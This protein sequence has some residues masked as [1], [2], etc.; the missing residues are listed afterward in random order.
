MVAIRRLRVLIMSGHVVGCCRLLCVTL[1]CL[2]LLGYGAESLART[3]WPEDQQRLRVGLRIFPAVLDALEG[4]GQRRSATGDLHVVVTYQ[5][6]NDVVHQVVTALEE[7]EQVQ[8]MPLTL[9]VLALE[10]LWTYRGPALGGI[11]VA[12]AD[13]EPASLQRLS[14]LHE[15]LVFSPFA[16]DVKAGAVAGIHVTD[17]I[18]PAINRAQA[19]RAG[20]RFKAFFLRVA[21]HA[22]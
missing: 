16:G 1:A 15:V 20:V 10:D 5:G 11:F 13:I 19:Q 7:I 14:V 4:L 18:L 8:N 22:E 2:T 6:A 21:H 12:S 9:K 3:L 17:R